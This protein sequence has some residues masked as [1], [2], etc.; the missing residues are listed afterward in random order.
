MKYSY[1]DNVPSRGGLLD[2]V[3][4]TRRTICGVTDAYGDLIAP[5]PGGM[6]GEI[7]E[8]YEY[9]LTG[10]LVS[11]VDGAGY[12]TSYQYDALNRMTMQTYPDNTYVLITYDDLNN[13]VTVTD[14]NGNSVKK[15]YDKLGNHIQ[16]V[17]VLT[18]TV[19][20][21]NEYDALSRLA[22]TVNADGSSK[23]EYN[24]TVDGRLSS[25]TVKDASDTVVYSEIYAYDDAYNGGA[26]ARVSKTVP[27]DSHAQDITTV[28]YYDPHGQKA[29]DGYILNGTEYL[30]DYYYDYSGNLVR[31]VTARH[32][33]EGRTEPYTSKY[34]YDYANRA[35]REY[36]IEGNY[37]SVEY[38]ELGRKIKITDY[39]ANNS[40]VSYSTI[41]EYDHA[42]RLLR[43]RIPFSLNGDGSITYSEKI[44]EYD[45]NGNVV[46]LLTSNNVPEENESFSRVD[47]GYDSNGRLVLVSLYDE[48]QSV[49][50]T[51][52]CYDAVGNKIRMFT[53]LSSPL[54]ITD[55]DNAT[56]PDTEF[57]VTKYEYDRFNRMIR[58]VDP[59]GNATTYEYD[60]N[61]NLVSVTDRNGTVTAYTYD[62]LGNKL[63]EVMVNLE[64]A[65]KNLSYEYSYTSTGQLKTVT[66]QGEYIVY[67]YDGAGRLMT[68]QNAEGVVKTYTYD[69]A[70]NKTGC[71][72]TVDGT[73]L[74]DAGYEYDGMNRLSVVKDNGIVTAI[75]GY[76]ANGNRAS[77]NTP[78]GM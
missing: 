55:P 9:D 11:Y 64:D 49:M 35:V 29:K 70:S 46:T 75:Y 48:G 16:E 77:L 53:G 60:Y 3:Y 34:E 73:V 50:H 68:E 31:V 56:G 30:N 57:S 72:V 42:G 65:D 17:D 22:K 4:V 45:L 33:A 27:G 62:A 15:V 51:Q 21:S 7:I 69:V 39:K 43:E 59:S 71:V 32:K 67:T 47:Y 12:V 40:P 36:N 13:Y 66:G 10:N 44:Y 20:L 58:T 54:T 18:G 37:T 41:F 19:L 61:G 26:Y 2:G 38:D 76:D 23:T 1:D 78:T 28:E 14:Q 6:P 25:K 8:T 74:Y 52:Y 5:S 63:T 24:Y